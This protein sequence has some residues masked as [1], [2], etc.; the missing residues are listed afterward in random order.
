MYGK[1][2]PLAMRVSRKQSN[3]PNECAGALLI[4]APTGSMMKASGDYFHP[5]ENTMSKIPSLLASGLMRAVT[6]FAAG[7]ALP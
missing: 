4:L 7:D 5:K 1:C 6:T 2:L 3:A